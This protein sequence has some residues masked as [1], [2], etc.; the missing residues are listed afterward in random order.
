MVEAR[1]PRRARTV[2]A[3]VATLALLALGASALPV[4]E[5]SGRVVDLADLLPAD[6]EAR[7]D[8]KLVA[9]EQR[10]GAQVAV[11]TV[12]SLE[13]DP[14]EDFSIRVV[15]AWK[16]GRQGKDDGVLLLVSRDDRKMRIE[17]GYGLEGQLTDAQSGRILD[18]VL[19]PRFR[20]GDYRGGIEEGVD[21]LLGTLDGLDVL[22]PE[23][24]P[25]ETP[26]GVRILGGLLFLVVIGTFSAVAVVAPGG[27]AWLLYVF[28]MPFYAAFP[29]ALF[30]PK[31]LVLFA[32]W[33]IGFP[34]LRLALKTPWGK[35][36]QK[37]FPTFDPTATPSRSRWSSGGWSSG[38]WSS[39]GWSSGGGGF[40][41]G[42]G[43]SGGGGSF[44]GGGASSSW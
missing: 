42:G 31:A 44:G 9:F 19:R 4:P 38:G 24:A 1:R 22:P 15:E 2:V 35:A 7:I 39:G 41:S 37:Q 34:I 18:G 13:G 23:P 32:L 6:A 36:F 11:L 25:G 10:T 8:A 14:I 28:L 3:T 16:L 40:S 29:T 30:G 33:V 26:W 27:V 21:T 17:T 20:A 12:T 5:L 43:F